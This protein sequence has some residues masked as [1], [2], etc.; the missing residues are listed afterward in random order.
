[1]AAKIKV[2]WKNGPITKR[3]ILDEFKVSS[4]CLVSESIIKKLK[5]EWKTF[6]LAGDVITIEKVED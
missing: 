6:G 4:D 5:A 3:R 2:V 1:M